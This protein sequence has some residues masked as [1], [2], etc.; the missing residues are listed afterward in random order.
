M[1]N[2]Q[3]L[4]NNNNNNKIDTDLRKKENNTN[5]FSNRNMHK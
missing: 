4:R 3:I 5:K 2:K 1:L